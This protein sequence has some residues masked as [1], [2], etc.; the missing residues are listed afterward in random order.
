LPMEEHQ[1]GARQVPNDFHS[2]RLSSGLSDLGLPVSIGVPHTLEPSSSMMVYAD[3]RQW[4]G[5]SRAR[6]LEELDQ[7]STLCA[8]PVFVV[9]FQS[10]R[11]GL[12][13]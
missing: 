4:L 2:I 9:V 3:S 10:F 12:L 7:P 6:V 11:R 5:F 13:L 8:L 1:Q